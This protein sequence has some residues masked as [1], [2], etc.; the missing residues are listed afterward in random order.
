[1][2]FDR[3]RVWP[4]PI[5]AALFCGAVASGAGS[6]VAR[7][8]IGPESVGL[9]DRLCTQTLRVNEEDRLYG[10]ISL[11]VRATISYRGGEFRR[12]V[13][14]DAVFVHPEVHNCL[15]KTATA[16]R[17][18]PKVTQGISPRTS[19]PTA[20]RSRQASSRRTAWS[21]NA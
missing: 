14:D 8:Q 5:L 7:A 15:V 18:S 12:N 11:S 10:M 17:K 6:G 13:I 4:R 16:I 20:W 2:P 1:M 21:W 9:I 19:S 3:F